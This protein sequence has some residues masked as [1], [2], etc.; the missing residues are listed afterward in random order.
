MRQNIFNL[1]KNTNLDIKEEYDRIYMLFEKTSLYPFKSILDY[2]NEEK[3]FE[4]KYRGRFL[5]IFDV[6][7][8]LKI[9][10]WQIELS[11]STQKFNIETLIRYIEFVLNM[12]SLIE[13]DLFSSQNR[14]T[15]K[16]L[17]D[18][19]KTLLEDLNYEIYKTNNEQIIIIEKDSKTT[20][21]AEKFSDIS[22]TVI[23]YRRFAL[24]GDIDTKKEII[25]KLAN[26]VEPL[27]KK[28]NGTPYKNILEDINMLLNNLNIRHNNL[29]G[30]K[31][32]EYTACMT[33]EELEKWYDTTY[34]I[35]L[36]ALMLE[37]YHNKKKTIEELKS[38]Y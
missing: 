37:D 9:D 14:Q 27:R 25:L 22:D 8:E 38:H 1:L 4:W 17:K 34:D 13:F 18:N 26:K 7:E 31:K 35:I 3:F 19:I 15:L 30:T 21:V 20:A 24:K 36:S 16:I 2:I 10:N 5:N 33:K 28:F 6:M 23:E 29:E 32:K 12:L 11:N